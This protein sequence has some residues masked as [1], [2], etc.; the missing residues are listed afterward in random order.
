M[1]II[2]TTKAPIVLEYATQQEVDRSPGILIEN[3]AQ[4]KTLIQNARGALVNCKLLL[5]RAFEQNLN[6][7][8]RTN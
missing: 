7:N 5:N 2:L 6:Y 8:G 1:R 4:K 3:G